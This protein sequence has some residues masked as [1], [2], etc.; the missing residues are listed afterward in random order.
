MKVAIYARVSSDD[1]DCQIQLTNLRAYVQRC[2]WTDTVEYI[3]KLSGKEGGKRPQLDRLLEAVRMQRVDVVVVWKMDRFGRSTLDTLQNIKLLDLHK[4]R[5][6]CP[7]MGID[8]DNQSPTGK[9]ILT[10]FAAV[11]ELER[12]FILERTQGGYKAYRANH[13][14]GRVGKGGVRDSK[15]KKNLP[16]GRPRRVVDRQRIADLKAG[17]LSIREIAAQLGIGKGTAERLMKASQ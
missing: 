7:S 16:V 8:T 14:A 13:A 17:G 11:A 4:V 6:L 15:S 3:E 12:G 5:F 10:I 1:Q 9:F 2:G